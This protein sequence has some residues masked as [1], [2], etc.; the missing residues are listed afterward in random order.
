[1]INMQVLVTGLNDETEK[2]L[3]IILLCQIISHTLFIKL[4]K[5]EIARMLSI[6]PINITL[7]PLIM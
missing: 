5:E 4:E 3:S 6:L 7:S 2:K 1:M